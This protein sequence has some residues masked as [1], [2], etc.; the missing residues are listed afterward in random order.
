MQA[1]CLVNQLLEN[2]PSA[3][4]SPPEDKPELNMQRFVQA[5]GAA[6]DAA[7]QDVLPR[8]KAGV[9]AY[10]K[11]AHTDFDYDAGGA[12]TPVRHYD[13]NDLKTIRRAKTFAEVEQIL[14]KYEVD[15]P[16]LAMAAQGYF[17]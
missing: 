15:P 8:F 12:R 9:Q 5:I 1:H 6:Q 13:Q 7:Q 10:I 11:W 2:T 4:A 3:A 14:R 17:V 16:F